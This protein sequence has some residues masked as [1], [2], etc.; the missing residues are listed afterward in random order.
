[1]LE[2]QIA[3]DRRKKQNIESSVDMPRTGRLHENRKDPR[4][5]GQVV[6]NVEI[7]FL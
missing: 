2:S 4:D 3:G 1:M 6:G 7:V 5:C